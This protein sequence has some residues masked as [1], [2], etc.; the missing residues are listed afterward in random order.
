MKKINLF[1]ILVFIF[2]NACQNVKDGIS[3]AKRD[4]SDEFL[5]E[6]KNP[7]TIPPSFEELPLPSDQK[8]PENFNET[9]ESIKN[10]LGASTKEDQKVEDKNLSLEQSI[11]KNI[12][13]KIRHITPKDIKISATLN[14]NQ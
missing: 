1:L 2:L 9:N 6:K 8:K 3:G 10:L 11:L 7:L 12:S 14:I 4:N 13:T 5:V